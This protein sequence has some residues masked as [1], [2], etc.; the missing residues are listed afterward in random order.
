MTNSLSDHAEHPAIDLLCDLVRRRS[1]TPEDAGCQEVLITR[2]QRIG[3]VCESMQFGDVSNLWARRGEAGP[4]LCFAGHTDVVPPGAESDWQSDP[5]EPIVR[6]GLLFGRGSADMKSGLAA[7]IV[8][9]ERFIGEYP[10]HKGS[11]AL[12]ITSD[13]EGRARDG[14]LKVVEA[15]TARN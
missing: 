6:D 12:L 15:L 7:M 10:N 13:E 14:T 2:L 1:V 3:F 8:A 5:F 4:V 11:L 9:L